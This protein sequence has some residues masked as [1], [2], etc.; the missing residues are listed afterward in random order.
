V[1][2]FRQAG[3]E[4]M[5]LPPRY[6]DLDLEIVI[7]VEPSSFPGDVAEAVLTALFGKRG[8]FPIPGFFHP[9]R[10]TFGTALDRSE[11]EAT[12]QRV[13]GVRA[14]ENVRIR[15]RAVFDWRDFRELLYQPARDEVIRVDNDPLHPDRGTLR[16]LTDGG[17]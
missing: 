14:V 10:F 7:C 16:L 9:D 15:R 17:A 3:R 12:V 11:L 13:P 4:V 1:D 8:V 5:V 2:R 6:A